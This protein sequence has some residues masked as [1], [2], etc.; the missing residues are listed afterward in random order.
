MTDYSTFRHPITHTEDIRTAAEVESNAP[1]YNQYFILPEDCENGD[2]VGK[3]NFCGAT[4]NFLIED[5]QLRLTIILT[6]L[7]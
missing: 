7:K 2:H 1:V 5:G 3:V 6:V 4:R